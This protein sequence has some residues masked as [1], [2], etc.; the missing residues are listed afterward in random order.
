MPFEIY[1][2]IENNNIKYWIPTLVI[3]SFIECNQWNIAED[4]QRNF[5]YERK[6]K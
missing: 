1:G 4:I 5:N 2:L 3:E 6:Q